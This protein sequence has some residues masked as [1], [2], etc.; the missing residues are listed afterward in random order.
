MF[1]FKKNL[2]PIRKQSLPPCVLFQPSFSNVTD[3]GYD[4][5]HFSPPNYKCDIFNRSGRELVM[6]F[7]R[8]FGSMSQHLL[9]PHHISKQALLQFTITIEPAA[10]SAQQGDQIGIIFARWVIVYFGQCF[11]LF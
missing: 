9:P 11:F 1:F 7:S 8:P 5:K 10:G 4:R 6:T 3:Y 2:R